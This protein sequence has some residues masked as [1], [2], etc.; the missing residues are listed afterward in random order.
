MTF[1]CDKAAS[2]GEDNYMKLRAFITV[3]LVVASLN[4]AHAEESFTVGGERPVTVNLPTSLQNP[5]PLLILLHSAST[6]S[7]HQERYMKLAAVAKSR[8]IIYIAP[9]GTKNQEGKRFWNAAKA[10]CDKYQ[11]GVDDVAFLN[12]LIDEI[13]LR[14]PVDFSR[15]YLIGHSNG[16]FMSFTFACKSNRIAAIVA[17]AGAMDTNPECSTTN[18]ISLLDIHGTEDKT[19]KIGGGVL[20]GFS[21]TSAAT[22]VKRIADANTCS[23]A[24]THK[25]DFEPTIKGSETTIFNYSC[26]FQRHLQY[27]RIK[28][29]SHS[30]VL[31]K[32]FAEQVIGFLIKQSRVR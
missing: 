14:T 13:N 30:P 19:I 12:S 7:A 1:E 16:A 29:G 25:I 5:A 11:S 6:S 4:S 3:A 8:G 26:K 18:P 22:T 2:T 17:I 24:I 9:D 10:C 15:I 21:Y 28:G 23:D 20:N 31:P 27:W 32:D